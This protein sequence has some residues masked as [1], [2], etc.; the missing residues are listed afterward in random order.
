[1]GPMS[2]IVCGA[3]MGAVGMAFLVLIWSIRSEFT[4]I[5]WHNA[6]LEDPSDYKTS[7]G[8]EV[9]VCTASGRLVVTS[10]YPEIQCYAA[11]YTYGTRDDKTV[12]HWAYAVEVGYTIPKYTEPLYNDHSDAI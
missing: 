8:I 11:M 10:Y 12:T 5:K 6:A 1:M 9:L 3:I 7:E 2:F 4:E